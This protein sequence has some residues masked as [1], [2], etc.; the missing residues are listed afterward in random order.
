M[1][2]DVRKVK[3]LTSEMLINDM[4]YELMQREYNGLIDE[5]EEGEY[6][7]LEFDMDLAYFFRRV[8][9]VLADKD[10]PM[11]AAIGLV[12]TDEMLITL[13]DEKF[14]YIGDSDTD[15]DIYEYV[16]EYGYRRYDTVT[17]LEDI[18][19]EVF[20]ELVH[21][22]STDNNVEDCQFINIIDFK[23]QNMGLF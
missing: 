13:F 6:F 4:M 12:F 15:E 2:T 20:I 3:K 1:K 11:R 14:D 23:T 21:I 17:H 5:I 8:L 18:P 7:D 19:E 9:S 10:I 16:I 22:Y